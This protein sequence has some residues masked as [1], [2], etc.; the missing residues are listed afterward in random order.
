YKAQQAEGA[1][2]AGPGAGPEAG[3]GAGDAGAGA[4]KDEKVQHLHLFDADGWAL[5]RQVEIADQSLALNA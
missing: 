2:A 3:P 1:A 5:E 4:A